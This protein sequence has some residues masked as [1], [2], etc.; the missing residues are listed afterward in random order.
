VEYLVY[1][2]DRWSCKKLNVKI[3]NGRGD[4]GDPEGKIILK[5]IINKWSIKI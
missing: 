5:R 2:A 3:R 1:R 4:F